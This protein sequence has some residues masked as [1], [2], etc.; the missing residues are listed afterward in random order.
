MR[1]G[2]LTET[3]QEVGAEKIATAHNADDNAETVLLHLV[4]G[5]GLDG[6]TGIPPVQGL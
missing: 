4:R 5:S 6:L 2:F 1:Y 3:A